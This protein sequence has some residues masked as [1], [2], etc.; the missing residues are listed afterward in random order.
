M[1]P[2]R[3]RREHRGPLEAV[4]GHQ[5]ADPALGDSILAGHLRLGAAVDDNS[6]MTRRAFDTR[7]P[8]T[9]HPML[10]SCDTLFVCPE[11]K[12]CTCHRVHR[13]REPGLVL[14]EKPVGVS[15]ARSYM[16]FWIVFDLR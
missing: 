1:R 3:L 7:R 14:A 12:H 4:A 10:M 8:S 11:T 16:A 2:T 15:I 6:G 13:I 5:T 9:G